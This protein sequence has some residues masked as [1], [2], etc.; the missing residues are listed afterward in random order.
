M[1]EGRGGGCP[2]PPE[3]TLTITIHDLP[4]ARAALAACPDAHLVTAPGAAAFWGAG[5]TAALESEL[6]HTLIVDCGDDPAVAMA[7]LRAGSR[8]LLFTGH[9]DIAAKL[10]SMAEQQGGRVRTAL[11]R[12]HLRLLPE[13]DPARAIAARLA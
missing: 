8:D 5:Y 12:P 7:A 2:E 1:G 9:A 6:G 3:R 13:D 4:Q 10:A 11:P